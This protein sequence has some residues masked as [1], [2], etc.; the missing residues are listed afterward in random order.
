MN[1]LAHFQ[2]AAAHDGWLVGALLGDHIKGPLRAGD[3]PPSWLTGIRL[4]R[5]IDAVTDHHPIL[6]DCRASLPAE[7]RRYAGIIVDVC[8]DHWLANHWAE[9]HPQPLPEFEQRVYGVLETALPGMPAGA[10]RRTE[11]LIRYQPLGHYRDWETVS[12][13]LTRISQRLSRPNPLAT[14]AGQLAALWPQW[15]QPFARF[16]ADLPRH[17]NVER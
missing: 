14:A 3:W 5:R 17:L 11:A 7:L 6:A 4:H 12:A 8:I 1:D 16:Y 15:Q 10:R 13:A 9:V 2:L